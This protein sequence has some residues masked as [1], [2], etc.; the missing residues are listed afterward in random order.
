LGIILL[1]LLSEL[2]IDTDT[3]DK[4]LTSPKHRYDPDII[5]IRQQHPPDPEITTGT[6]GG[7]RDD[8]LITALKEHKY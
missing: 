8:T 7:P 6:N 4:K 5:G 3:K 1:Q 2:F